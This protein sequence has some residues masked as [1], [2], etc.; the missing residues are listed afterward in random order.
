MAPQFTATRGP[1]AR[2]LLACSA[3][4]TSSL[5]VPD[6]PRM[7]TGAM[8]RATLATRSLTVRMASDSPTRRSSEALQ[9]SPGS[10]DPLRADAARGLRGAGTLSPPCTADATTERNCFRSTGLVR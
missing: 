8:P 3:R 5:P 6:S 7:S 10:S 2:W 9:V 1:W 4:A